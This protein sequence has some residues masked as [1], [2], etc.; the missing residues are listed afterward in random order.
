LRYGI[1]AGK[2]LTNCR[3][4]WDL[5]IGMQWAARHRAGKRLQVSE[6]TISESARARARAAEGP[7]LYDV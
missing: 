5:R 6:I 3:F 1:A 4:E 7:A 2:K